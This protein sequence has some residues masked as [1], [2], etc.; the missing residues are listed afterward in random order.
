MSTAG[1]ISFE[2]SVVRKQK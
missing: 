2:W 1:K